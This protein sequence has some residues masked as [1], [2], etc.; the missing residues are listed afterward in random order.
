MPDPVDPAGFQENRLDLGPT[1][2]HVYI[3]VIQ[4]LKKT[5]FLSHFHCVVLKSFYC[6]L[7]MTFKL[8]LNP[9]TSFPPKTEKS[10]PVLVC[11]LGSVLRNPA[12][13]QFH[14]RITVL[15]NVFWKRLNPYSLFICCAG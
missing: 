1:A 12:T 9:I 7:Y 5:A 10:S 6:A 13:S 3:I 15:G 2:G 11:F 8:S 14:F 4:G